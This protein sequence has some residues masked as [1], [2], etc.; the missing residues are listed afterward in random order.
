M[1]ARSNEP[2][3]SEAGYI[4]ARP[5][6]RSTK[7]LATHGRTIHEGQPRQRHLVRFQTKVVTA[8]R[9]SDAVCRKET[10]RA[11]SSNPVGRKKRSGTIRSRLRREYIPVAI[12]GQ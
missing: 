3:Q 5:K 10:S 2:L 7:P 4:D 6:T 9:R 11:Y 8:A 1:V 12:L